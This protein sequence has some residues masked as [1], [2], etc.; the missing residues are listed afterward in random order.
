M[1]T[2]RIALVLLFVACLLSVASS[3]SNIQKRKKQ[4]CEDP[5]TQFEMNQC[6]HKEYEAADAEL[7]KTYN[8]LAAKLDDEQR[9]KL[10][11][12]ELAWIMYRDTNC[13]LEGAFYK[14]GTMR[15]MVESYCRARMTNERTAE[16]KAQIKT[17]EQ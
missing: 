17:Y 13:D 16:L 2:K 6:A 15:P 8:R 11:E 7:N 3:A 4:P 12:A 10:K 14:G 1:K 9:G 5:S